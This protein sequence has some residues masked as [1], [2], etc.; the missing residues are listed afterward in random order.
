MNPA[1]PITPGVARVAAIIRAHV[2]RPDAPMP[3]S[4]R[5]RFDGL[6][7]CPIGLVPGAEEPTPFRGVDFAK[8][9]PLFCVEGVAEFASWWDAQRD[10]RAAMD[11]VWPPVL[12]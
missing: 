4:N 11:V 6:T 2:P 8:G 12:A 5:F 9:S 1:L 3:F 10:V 7:A